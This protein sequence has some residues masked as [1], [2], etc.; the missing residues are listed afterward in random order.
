M[1]P[2]YPIGNTR[3]R[4]KSPALREQAIS[5]IAEAPAKFALL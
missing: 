3:R 5:A 4:S 2:R 1:D